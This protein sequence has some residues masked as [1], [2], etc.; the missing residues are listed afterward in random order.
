MSTDI[1]DQVAAAA[2]GRAA[3]DRATRGHTTV[4]PAVVERIAARVAT[5][6]PGVRAEAVSTVRS[7]FGAD[8]SADGRPAIGAD[9]DLAGGHAELRLTVGVEWPRQ[10]VATA[11]RVRR[12]VTSEV[13]RLAG[14]HVCRIDIE[15]TDL[16][17]RPPPVRV[18]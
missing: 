4:A 3:D 15:V 2:P 6:V 5:E 13:R 7:W 10:V 1:S 12:I 16:P 14:V 18:Q 17:G 11:E 9:A 8:T